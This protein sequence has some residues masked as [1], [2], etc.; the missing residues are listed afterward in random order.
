MNTEGFPSFIYPL[1]LSH[2]I[3]AVMD[4][5]PGTLWSEIS[6]LLCWFSALN[7]CIYCITTSMI[8][9]S[10]VNKN[11]LGRHVKLRSYFVT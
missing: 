4:L 9:I 11:Q 3:R 5:E 1:V 10:Y 2:F 8:I 7:I 6:V